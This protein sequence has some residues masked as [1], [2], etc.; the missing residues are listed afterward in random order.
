[1]NTH[2]VKLICLLLAA[3][4][5]VCDAKEPKGHSTVVRDGSTMD[6]AIIIK[7]PLKKY[8]DAEWSYI[9]RRYPDA[10]EFPGEQAMLIH[11]DGYVDAMTFTT[12]HGR[13][14]MY[15]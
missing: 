12:S 2:S 7:V 13:K 6:K 8:V 14:T 10:Q 1:M 4:I 5:D 9:R 15:F 11:R 3:S